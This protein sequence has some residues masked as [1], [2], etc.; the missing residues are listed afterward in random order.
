M[1]TEKIK[2][3]NFQTVEETREEIRTFLQSRELYP[4]YSKKTKIILFSAMGCLI[5]GG[6]GMIISPLKSLSDI[7]N[8]IFGVC[9]LVMLVFLFLIFIGI[10]RIDGYKKFL[11]KKAHEIQISDITIEEEAKKQFEKLPEQIEQLDTKESKE[12]EEA[13]KE[14]Q[15]NFQE[16]KDY[17]KNK[18]KALETFLKSA[19]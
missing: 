4:R 9:L 6:I 1:K 5:L 14:I 19:K 18:Q 15:K 11:Q 17:L 16:A 2:T 12:I 8:H 10:R 7:E 13:Q 3:E